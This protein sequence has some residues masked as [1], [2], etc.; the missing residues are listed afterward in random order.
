M[1]SKTKQIIEKNR[2]VY[3]RIAEP[4]AQSRKFLWADLKPLV[5]YTAEGDKVLDLGCGTGRLYQLFQDIQDVEY[6]GLDQ[7]EGQIKVAQKNY[8]EA[9]FVVGEMTELPFGDN[10][11]AVVYC[12][13]TFHHLP[14]EE[15]RLQALQEMKRVLKL[16]G[17]LVMTNWNLL[18]RWGEGKVKRKEYKDLGKG[19]FIVPWKDK[20]GNILGERYYHGFGLEE[21]EDL[22]KKAGFELEEQYFAKHSQ[23]TDKDQGE[24]II[25]IA[26]M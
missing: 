4:F 10:E 11:F 26:K 13:A 25:S 14:D 18:G 19:D 24:N 15:T 7:S 16:E 22:F 9:K 8:S 1:N 23:K 6:I 21:L 3:D 12:V 5:V 20:A 17:T 2:Q